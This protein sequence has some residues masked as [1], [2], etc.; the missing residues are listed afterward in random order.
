MFPQFLQDP[1]GEVTSRKIDMEP[2]NQLFEKDN[3]LPNVRYCVP[4]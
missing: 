2:K 4:C 1:L 3:H